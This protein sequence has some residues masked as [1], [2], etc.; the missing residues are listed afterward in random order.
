MTPTWFDE[1]TDV[2]V[3][4][5]PMLA[6]ENGYSVACVFWPLTMHA[7]LDY[8]LYRKEYYG[9]VSKKKEQI[10]ARSSEGLFDEV[11]PVIQDAF[12]LDPI[13]VDDQI[14]GDTC[15]YLIDHY[16][17]E[18]IYTHLVAIDSI[19][20]QKGVFGEHILDTY[21]FLDGVVG[22]ITDALKRNG[23]FE[24]TIINVTAD[25]GHLDIDRVVSI[26]RFLKD[27]GFI[28]TD[29]EGN[30]ISWDAYMH[31]CALSGHVYIKN[32]DPVITQK[33]LKHFG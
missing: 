32:E 30:L 19:R 6:K 28:K 24:K 33:A 3:P 25:H 11:Y 12:N 13:L 20:H 18:V 7:P 10:R 14:C 17:P 2:K 21:Q 29:E 4:L 22:Q 9:P 16:Q 8:V 1:Y 27:E 31:S 15:A 26:N 23:L 5:L